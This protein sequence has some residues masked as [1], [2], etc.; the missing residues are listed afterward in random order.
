MRNEL[1]VSAPSEVPT[2]ACGWWHA[3]PGSNASRT[4][5]HEEAGRGDFQRSSPTGCCAYGIPRNT[6]PSPP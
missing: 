5:V 1:G 6:P 4:A 3:G 2:R